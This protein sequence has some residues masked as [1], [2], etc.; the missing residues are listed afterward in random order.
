MAAAEGASSALT[1]LDAARRQLVTAVHLYVADEDAVAIHTLTEAAHQILM[2][3]KGRQG[4][5]TLKER[6]IG[7]AST[8][9]QAGE[10]QRALNAPRNFFKH[11]DS[12]GDR[13]LDFKPSQTYL[14]LA[15][16][17]WLY[18]ELTGEVVPQ[19]FAYSQWYWLGP[20]R[21]FGDYNT[22]GLI[23]KLREMWPNADKRTFFRE[24]IGILATIDLL[25][26]SNPYRKS[27][28]E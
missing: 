13:T 20:G 6:V 10:I 9:E 17:C 11:A 26:I 16:A 25:C 1:K 24:V 22:D 8:P 12:D 4:E 2:N 21:E 7:L 23:T 3:L 15:S 19:L 14:Y 5:P 27:D 18:R 28:G